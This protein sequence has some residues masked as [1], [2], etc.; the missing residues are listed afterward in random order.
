MSNNNNPIHAPI[1]LHHRQLGPEP[2]VRLA[3]GPTVDPATLAQLHE[4]Q[5]QGVSYG[6]IIDRLT[7]HAVRM[8]YNPATNSYSAVTKSTTQPAIT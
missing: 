5:R 4:W 1:P 6:V 8:G 2:R 3:N 7:E